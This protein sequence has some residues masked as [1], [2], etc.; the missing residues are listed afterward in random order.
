MRRFCL[1]RRRE[2]VVGEEWLVSEE[3]AYLPDVHEEVVKVTLY[4]SK[5]DYV[6]LT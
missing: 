3:G 5:C 1:V 2:R 4:I 6:Y